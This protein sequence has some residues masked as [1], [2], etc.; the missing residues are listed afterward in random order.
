MSDIL[1]DLAGEQRARLVGSV[2]G[3]AEREVYPQLTPQQRKAFRDKVLACVGVYH[4]F[5]LDCLRAA[6]KGSVV[7]E[8]A[9]RL[10][11][12]IHRQLT[13]DA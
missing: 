8:E 2:L 11:G 4:D 1:A 12:D 10:L 13:K 7:N 9:M 6:N 5:V 3:H